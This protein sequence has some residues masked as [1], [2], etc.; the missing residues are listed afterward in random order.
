LLN[1]GLTMTE[2]EFHQP[3]GV[4]RLLTQ[5]ASHPAKEEIGL[6][7]LKSMSQAQY[8][9]RNDGHFGLA[10]SHYT[11]FTSP[12]RR[13]PDLIVHRALKQSLAGA[14]P[15]KAPPENSGL[16]LSTCER[17]AGE[18]E[19][20]VKRLYRVLYMERFVGETFVGT[21]SGLNA[22]GLWVTLNSH[23]VDGML[24]L[25]MLPGDQYRFD[26]RRNVVQAVRGKRQIALAQRLTVQ[27]VRAERLTQ[28]L[29]FGFVAWDWEEEPRK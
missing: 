5:A 10:A 7:I 12:I 26:P 16:Q 4:N 28:Q 24:P 22:R 18:A 20:R 14:N 15:A 8:R 6:A 3:G 21:V 17:T 27:L 23:F 29:E 2:K 13:Y 19:S 1:F 11:H 25:A 9:A